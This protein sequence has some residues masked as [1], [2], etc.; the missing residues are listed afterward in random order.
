MASSDHVLLV[1]AS[2]FIA[3]KLRQHMKS[4]Q[5]TAIDARVDASTIDFSKYS[6]VLNC[7]LDPDFKIKKYSEARDL[8]LH[9]ARR[10][11]ET[12]THFVMLSSRK[13]Y[14]PVS[15]ASKVNENHTPN[16]ECR[17]GENK[18]QSEQRIRSELPNDHSVLRVANVFGFE[19]GRRS[20]MGLALASLKHEG[21]INL[22]VSPFVVRD[23]IPVQ[24]FCVLLSA[25]CKVRPIGTFNAGSGTATAVGQI[26]LWLIS[27]YGRGELVIT[28][29]EKR[30]Q[31]VLDVSR[32]Y[33]AINTLQPIIDFEHEFKSLGEKLSNG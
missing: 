2:S 27:G 33:A 23:F 29:T 22:D 30:D 16:P 25:I 10:A 13:I 21:R 31:F 20:F 17:Y 26:G 28:R 24:Q 6:V 15:A 3:S 8:D 11:A 18:L 14:G 12:G 19:L 1:G 32:L 5:L 9:F 4:E 7:A